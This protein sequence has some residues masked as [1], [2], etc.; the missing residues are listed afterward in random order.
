MEQAL[1]RE[2]LAALESV[3]E[4]GLARLN[5]TSLTIPQFVEGVDKVGLGIEMERLRWFG[6][7]VL[8]GSWWEVMVQT[9]A[10]LHPF[11]L[12]QAVDQ[13]NALVGQVQK[14]T[15]Q[16]ER[17]LYA[18][19]SA[20]LLPPD[21]P[22]PAVAAAPKPAAASPNLPAAAQ[23]A[24]GSEPTASGQPAASGATVEQAGEQGAAAGPAEGQG[25]GPDVPDL[26]EFYEEFEQHRQQVGGIQAVCWSQAGEGTGGQPLS[27]CATIIHAR[28]LSPTQATS[29]PSCPQR[30]RILRCVG[31]GWAGGALPGRGPA[32]GQG[33]G[34]GCG[35][36]HRQVAVPGWVSAFVWVGRATGCPVC[37]WAC[38]L[39]SAV[40]EVRSA[41]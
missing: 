27:A 33:G 29:D 35:H 31:G 30:I 12:P 38:K 4:P 14:N 6:S 34:A 18:I 17:I 32:A 5:W 13:F 28:L 19:T 1:L 11:G 8:A 20:R 9:I 25:S 22:A 10:R 26:Q 37:Q 40:V 21:T 15:A 39:G 3:L 41:L 2:Q 7:R 16:I 36:Q 24:A 23:P